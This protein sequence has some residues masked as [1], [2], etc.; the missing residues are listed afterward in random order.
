MMVISSFCL[1]LLFFLQKSKYPRFESLP[2][3]FDFSSAGG[4]GISMILDQSVCDVFNFQIPDP[5]NS[6]T[7]THKL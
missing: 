6:K 7:H 2:K 5:K 4:P 1:Q 3:A